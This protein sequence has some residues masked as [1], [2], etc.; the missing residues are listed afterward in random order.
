MVPHDR[1]TDLRRPPSA[2]ARSSTIEHD[3]MRRVREWM[4]GGPPPHGLPSLRQPPT[5][6]A[7][8]DCLDATAVLMDRSP[9]VSLRG[10][11]TSPRS[12][13]AAH[14][15]RERERRA[16]PD[17]ARHPD[18]SPVQLD[19][20]ARER[21]PKPRALRLLVRRPHLAKLLEHRLLIPRRDADAG[22]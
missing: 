3:I 10:F 7:V 9:G 4:A 14:R 12:F 20:L 8:E 15:K 6:R 11:A 17:L 13:V 21:Q 18:P 22:V 2:I 5:A 16:D 19:E 1:F